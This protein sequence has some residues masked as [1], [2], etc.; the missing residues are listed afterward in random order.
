V[1]QYINIQASLLRFC[2]DNAKLMRTLTGKDFESLNLDA[3]SNEDE[4]PAGDFIGIEDLA[5]QSASD[6]SP[7]DSM[8]V[9]IT[10]STVSDVNNMRLTKVVDHIYECVRPD[11]SLT[12]FDEGTGNRIGEIK[13]VRMSQ[14]LPV[15]DGKNGRVFQSVVFQAAALDGRTK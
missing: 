7:L 2:S 6:S 8:S 3:F 13:C 4:L 10:I 1:A 5:L 14:I 11:K 12:L 9:A 15:Q